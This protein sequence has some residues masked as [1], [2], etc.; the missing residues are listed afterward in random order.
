MLTVRDRIFMAGFVPHFHR[1][2]QEWSARRTCE[3]GQV[4]PTRAALRRF[5]ESVPGAVFLKFR[6]HE[7]QQ[8]GQVHIYV[9]F[10][11][12]A[13]APAGGPRAAAIGR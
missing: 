5:V 11:V 6:E 8:P 12:A 1:Q 9:D 3:R 13:V 10:R 2:R 4:L 7:T